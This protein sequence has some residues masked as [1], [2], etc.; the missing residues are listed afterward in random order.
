MNTANLP[1][2]AGVEI[3]TDEAGRFDLNALHNA[4]GL[5]KNKAP[6]QWL[7]TDSA[8]DL[9]ECLQ[10]QTANLQLG[11]AVIS[12][13]QGGANPGTF[14]HELLAIA[15][16]SWISPRFQLEVNRVFL[17]YRRGE[18]VQSC[19]PTVLRQRFDELVEAKAKG[20]IT[21]WDARQM[22]IDAIKSNWS[23]L[24]QVADENVS[25][26]QLILRAKL[27]VSGPSFHEPKYMT[28]YEM[29]S[30]IKNHGYGSDECL[31]AL[32]QHGIDLHHNEMAFIPEHER[33]CRLVNLGRYDIRDALINEKH[34]RE[35]GHSLRVGGKIYRNPVLIPVDAIQP[36]RPARCGLFIATIEN[37]I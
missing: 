28:I 11:H 33:L 18:L 26:F 10:E 15:Y 19:T 12:V 22:T 27:K 2:V 16:A 24:P 6:N 35:A 20:L 29:I 17:A 14:A 5:G 23:A 3:T 37:P 32:N 21:P 8:K 9:L 31:R 7:R 4:S 30:T 36:P 34:F 1:V 25:V 13:V